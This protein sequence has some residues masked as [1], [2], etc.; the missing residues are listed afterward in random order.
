VGGA[1]PIIG[2]AAERDAMAAAHARAQT[3]ESQ[4]LLVTGP[5]G[6]GKTRLVE[7]LGGTLVLNGATLSFVVLC[8]QWPPA[9]RGAT[10][11]G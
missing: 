5:A 3:G 7:D 8:E 9:V 2:R 4:I 10:P 1:Q 11:H 6:I